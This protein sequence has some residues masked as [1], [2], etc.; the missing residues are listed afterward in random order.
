MKSIM[1]KIRSG[2]AFSTE[3]DEYNTKQKKETKNILNLV[4]DSLVESIGKNVKDKKIYIPSNIKY[5]LPA[6]EKQFTGNFPSGTYVTVPKDMIFG[7]HWDN[8]DNHRIDLDLS[9]IN[10]QEGKIGWD[11]NYRN[12]GKTILFSG[13]MTN[14]QKG[15]TELFYVRRQLKQE[16]I[17]LVNYYNYTEGVDVPF[18]ILVVQEQVDNLSKNYMVDPDNVK[19]IAN[20]TMTK[21]EKQKI[22]G[23][24][25]TT[26]NECRFYFCEAYL[27]RSITSS[28]TS[29][30]ENTR[31]YLSTYYQNPIL[32]NVILEKAGARI[33]SDKEDCDIDL[34][35]ENIEKDTII[36]LL[37]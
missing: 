30:V 31:K 29:Y 26:T 8:V 35:P 33:V 1:Y 7:I 27:G 3:V 16:F 11:S 2:K 32:L 9:L 24:L 17:L 28:N 21:D 19:A 15:A 25:V 14:A 6:T 18:K 10:I 37:I 34:S 13:D 36:K 12:E 20:S 5:A 23:L 4:M 22:L